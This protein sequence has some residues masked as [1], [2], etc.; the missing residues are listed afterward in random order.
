MY[1]DLDLADLIAELYKTKAWE[2]LQQENPDLHHHLDKA[3]FSVMYET[4]L[5]KFK[6]KRKAYRESLKTAKNNS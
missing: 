1:S 4:E 2:Q 5:K 3:L 6:A